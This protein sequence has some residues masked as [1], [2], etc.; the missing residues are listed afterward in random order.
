MVDHTI[1]YGPFLRKA[2]MDGTMGTGHEGSY[3]YK[4]M[5]NKKKEHISCFSYNTQTSI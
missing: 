2:I 1:S 4:P 3:N 5:H